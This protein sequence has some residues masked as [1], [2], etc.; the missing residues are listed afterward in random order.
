MQQSIT[1]FELTNMILDLTPNQLR[2][3]RN[4]YLL[5]LK[6]SRFFDS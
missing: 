6:L 5:L 2:I 3:K 4:H 1:Q